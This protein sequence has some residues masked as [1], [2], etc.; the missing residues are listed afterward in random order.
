MPR[1][2]EDG[3][4]PEEQTRLDNGE[5]EEGDEEELMDED[6]NP[7][8]ANDQT[9]VRLQLELVEPKRTPLVLGTLLAI[10]NKYAD[11]LDM[12]VMIIRMHLPVTPPNCKGHPSKWT[13]PVLIK[14]INDQLPP[15]EAMGILATINLDLRNDRD[16]DFTRSGRPRIAALTKFYRDQKKAAK[17]KELQEKEAGAASARPRTVPRRRRSAPVS[18]RMPMSGC[19][20]SRP[21]GL[22][23]S[24]LRA[25][26]TA[27]RPGLRRTAA[28]TASA[29]VAGVTGAAPPSATCY[30]RAARSLR[31]SV[32]P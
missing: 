14:T 19:A 18:C 25:S 6:E 17:Q 24:G 27:S 26:R 20:R 4:V 5:E 32:P 12:A 31:Q 28:G 11:D 3:E 9:K 15:A 8:V 7:I 21:G 22:S 23:V 30:R 16:P 10:L 2:R 13:W 1:G 29:T